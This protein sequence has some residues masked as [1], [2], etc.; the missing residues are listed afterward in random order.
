MMTTDN[1]TVSKF[2]PT[3]KIIH[4]AL[5]MGQLVFTGVV[6][7]LDSQGSAGMAKEMSN[8]F[9]FL[10]LIFTGGGIFISRTFYKTKLATIDRGLPLETKLAQ[11]RAA[12]ITKLAILETPSI[13]A[14]VGFLITANY[15]ILLFA[16]L[17]IAVFVM[18]APT[19][20]KISQDLQLT[21]DEKIQL[22][23]PEIR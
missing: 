16:L 23:N 13:F 7:F 18:E 4:I 12:I 20:E 19:L 11:L 2:V 21:N 1:M 5:I 6:I 22:Q 14:V 8:I 17:V 3:L 15:L 9:L 10:A